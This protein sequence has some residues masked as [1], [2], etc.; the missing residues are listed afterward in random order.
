MTSIMGSGARVPTIALA[1]GDPAGTGPELAA[2]AIALPEVRAAMRL[3][4]VGDK[5]VLDAGAATAGVACDCTVV[6]IGTA[7]PRGSAQPVFVD[8]ENLDPA[9][10][11][12]GVASA[13]GGRFALANYAQALELV[14]DEYADAVCFTPFNR[15]A[16]RLADAAYEDELRFTGGALGTF[17]AVSE[18]DIADRVWC[19][20][21]TSHVPMAQMPSLLTVEAIVGALKLTHAALRDAGFTPPRIA[22]AALNPHAG[23]DGAFGREEIEI[24]S[25]AIR[26]AQG[27]GI[28]ADGPFAADSIFLRAYRGE[29][30]AVLTMYHDQGRIAMRLLGFERGVTLLGG[31]PFPICTPVHGTGYDIAGKGVAKVGAMRATLLLA[32]EMVRRAS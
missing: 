8:L 20:R 4:V 11:E 24:I 10:V 2:R 14:L 1:L 7:P 18:F 23:D 17:G 3:I 27:R 25:P 16:L 12:R 31:F 13:A 15:S 32:A 30:D 21:V 29:F 19:A 28:R 9:H 26:A 6:R 22:V 5:R